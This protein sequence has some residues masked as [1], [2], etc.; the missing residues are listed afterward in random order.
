[1]FRPPRRI[2]MSDPCNA[3]RS[4]PGHAPVIPAFLKIAACPPRQLQSL[5]TDMSSHL[6][7]LLPDPRLPYKNVSANVFIGH[8]AKIHQRE[9][10]DGGKAASKTRRN[11]RRCGGGPWGCPVDRIERP[12][13]QGYCSPAH[14]G[15]RPGNGESHEL[16][17]VGCGARARHAP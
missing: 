2:R 7:N 1:M 4:S 3:L 16:S 17:G 8:T 15:A 9:E 13:R 6:A 10:P 14:E 11:D 5:P 12:A